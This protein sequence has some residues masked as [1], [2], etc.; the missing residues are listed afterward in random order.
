ME[1]AG[2]VLLLAV[3]E[4]LAIDYWVAAKDFYQQG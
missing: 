1:S 4:Q 3:Y 2:V